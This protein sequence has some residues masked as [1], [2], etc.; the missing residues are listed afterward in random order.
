M[1]PCLLFILLLL[2]NLPNGFAQSEEE[3]AALVSLYYSTSG[4][5]W[6]Q[7]WDLGKPVSEWEGVVLKN[8]HVVEIHLPLNRLEGELPENFYKLKYLKRLNLA[9]NKLSGPLSAQWKK[10][11]SL[12]ELRLSQN[13]LS[14]AIP[15]GLK[16]LKSLRELYLADN[17]FS[18]YGA[19]LELRE[20]QLSMLDLLI[21]PQGKSVLNKQLRLQLSNTVFSDDDL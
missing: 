10:M 4:P 20:G 11:Q 16:K 1:R 18:E 8:G 19:L 3:Y 6:A 17:R 9:Y 12:E 15:T 13:N 2:S 14:G 7:S 21:E 5:Q